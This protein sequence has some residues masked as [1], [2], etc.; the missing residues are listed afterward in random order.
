[1]WKTDLTYYPHNNYTS[2]ALVENLWIK[3]LSV[4]IFDRFIV[5][6]FSTGKFFIQLVEMW[7]SFFKYLQTNK[8][9]HYDK[10]YAVEISC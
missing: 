1:M 4:E 2:T 9:S 10:F 7:K 5:I 8:I 3:I 6:Y